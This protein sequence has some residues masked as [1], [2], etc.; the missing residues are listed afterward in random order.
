M[1]EL[2]GQPVEPEAVETPVV[3]GTE[4]V[5][6][7]AEPEVRETVPFKWGRDSR[8]V[9]ADTAKSMADELGTSV[10]ALRT[11]VQMGRNA[12]D[13]YSETRRRDA[14][15]ARREA[16]IEAKAKAIQDRL[17]SRVG[18]STNGKKPSITEDPVAFWNSV[19]ARLDKLNEL[20]DVKREIA[21]TK[22]QI[23]RREQAE[24]DSQLERTFVK[25]HADLMAEYK[26]KDLPYVDLQ[27]I[28]QTLD[29]FVTEIPEDMSIRELIDM[30]YRILTWDRVGKAKAQAEQKRL[31]EPRARIEI[32][33][34]TSSG[35]DMGGDSA[36]PA[37][38][39][40]DQRRARLHRQ[41]GGLTFGDLAQG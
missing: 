21:E 13:I 34:G 29:R 37:G 7:P 3:P 20:E 5:T 9:D 27:T 22:A 24:S 15:L 12:A 41:V 4:A 16:E 25:E 39:T 26:G 40:L 32:P 19:D 10:E 18:P 1:T 2:N 14:E 30:G 23:S 31:R 11:W 17:D 38:E 8:E 28:A 36:P 33:S 6:P 35:A